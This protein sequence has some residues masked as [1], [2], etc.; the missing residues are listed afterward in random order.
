[1]ITAALAIFLALIWVGVCIGKLLIDLGVRNILDT[2][3]TLS[4]NVL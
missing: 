4:G 3:I 1:M 2:K